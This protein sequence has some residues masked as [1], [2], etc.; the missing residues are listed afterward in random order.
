MLTNINLKPICFNEM[1]YGTGL[2][3]Q[4]KRKDE[5]EYK[6]KRIIYDE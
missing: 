4:A 1:K 6:K 5:K 2:L 3:I